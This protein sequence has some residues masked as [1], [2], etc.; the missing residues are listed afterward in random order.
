MKPKYNKV[1]LSASDREQAENFIH[2]GKN[3]AKLVRKAN[4]LLDLDE[5]VGVVKT[6]AEIAAK[7]GCSTYCVSIVAKQYNS[8]GIE[9][10]L[11]RKKR[12]FPPVPSKITKDIEASILKLAKSEVPNGYKAWTLRLLREKVLE[13]GILEQIS[14]STIGLLLKKNHNTSNEK[15][16]SN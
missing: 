2:G 7:Y 13:L 16:C 8:E 1:Y 6:Q 3:N 9:R 5:N 15:N 14:H 10:I 4:I 11:I 12:E